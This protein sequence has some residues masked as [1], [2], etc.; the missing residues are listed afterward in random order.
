MKFKE[1]DKEICEMIKERYII[2]DNLELR[3]ELLSLSEEVLEYKKIYRIKRSDAKVNNWKTLVLVEIQANENVDIKAELKYT[4]S[5]IALIKQSLLGTENSDLYL[6]LA[7][8]SDNACLEECLRIEST[9]EFCRKFVLLPGESISDFLN[10]T[11]LQKM[12]ENRNTIGG[13]PLENALSKTAVEYGW[14]TNELKK[15]WKFAFLSLS[16]SDLA[17]KLLEEDEAQI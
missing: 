11:F 3:N 12:E 1:I 10:R 15:K 6:F 9:E 2:E 4:I 16:G 5:W 8:N 14:L 13:D 17:E 7:F